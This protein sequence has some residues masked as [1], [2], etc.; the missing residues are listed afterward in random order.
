MKTDCQILNQAHTVVVRGIAYDFPDA[1][2]A[3]AFVQA[4]EFGALP[5][6]AASLLLSREH[7]ARPDDH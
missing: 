3:G 2:M 5:P 7:V 1:L 4:V 6:Q